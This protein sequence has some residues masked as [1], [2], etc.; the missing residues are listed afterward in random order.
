MGIDFSHCDA[1]WSYGG[2]NHARTRLAEA[3]GFV[4]TDM[5]GFGTL[6]GQTPGARSWDEITDPVKPLLNHSDCDGELTAEECKAAA[7]RLREI[8]STWDADDYD[9]LHFEELA[10]GMD[11]AAEAGEPL[12]FR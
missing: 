2:F 4:L 12:E 9:R 1:H 7:P 3:V 10:R 5:Q 11:A 6:T 8:V